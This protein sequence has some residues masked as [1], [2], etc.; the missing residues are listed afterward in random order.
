M[1]AFTALPAHVDIPRDRWGRPLITPVDGGKPIA[2]TRVSTLAKALDDKTALTKWKQRQVVIGLGHRPDLVAVAQAVKNDDRK[3]DEIVHTAMT[4]AESERAANLGTALHALSE[5]VDDGVDIDTMPAEFRADLLA[6][7]T[8]TAG[9]EVLAKEMFVVTDEV[10]AA[11]TFD[12]LVR[13]PDG[14]A[15]IADI[16]TGKHEPKYPHG[17]AQQMAVYSRGHLYDPERGRLAHLPALGVDQSVG[18]LI[19]MP[20]GTG[21]CDLYLMDLEVGWALAQTAVAVKAAFKGNP[22]TQYQA[23]A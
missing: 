10:Q 19:H 22:I 3:L 6:Y 21:T 13:L 5:Q 18:L 23:N 7:R 4:A 11:G 9:L 16:K 17:A 1:T 20:A 2:Y 15:V 14:R 8:A 12:R